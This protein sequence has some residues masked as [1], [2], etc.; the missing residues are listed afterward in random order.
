MELNIHLQK[1]KIR[2]GRRIPVYKL[3]AM[4]INLNSDSV[5]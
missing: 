3:L 1:K 5:S 2:K 4:E